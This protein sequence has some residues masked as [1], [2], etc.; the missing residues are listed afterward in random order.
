MIIAFDA[1]FRYTGWVAI[2]G[3]RTIADCGLIVTKPTA[4][5]QRLMVID[6]DMECDRKIYREILEIL[7]RYTKVDGVIAELPTG[8]S[9]SSRAAACN[10]R[11]CAIFSCIFAQRDIPLYLVTP[12][13]I[14]E[15]TGSAKKTEKT[16]V[17][18]VVHREFKGLESL[19]RKFG[20]NSH[21]ITDAV[22]AF[23]AARNSRCPVIPLEK[24]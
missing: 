10:A 21:H 9:K 22:G 20:A 13:Q 18:D 24:S 14:K 5:K 6:A 19:I 16:D 17:A 7:D 12:S 23:I 1:S 4:K 3:G 15:L 8:G 2:L 11:I